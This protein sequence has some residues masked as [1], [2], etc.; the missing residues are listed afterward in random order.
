MTIAEN[1]Q[2]ITQAKEDLREAIN[3]KGGELAE[4]ARLEEFAEA[5]EYLPTVEVV[6]QAEEN[7]VNFYDYDGTVLYSYNAEEFLAM[8]E[9]PN[10][11]KQRGLVCQGWNWELSDAKEF[12]QRHG[13]LDIGATYITDDGRTRLYITVSDKT[14]KDVQIRCRTASQTEAITINWGDG[15]QEDLPNG[16]VNVFHTYGHSGDYVISFIVPSKSLLHFEGEANKFCVMGDYN[17]QSYKRIGTLKRLE[18]GDRTNIG[19]HSFDGCYNL[20]HLTLPT[21]ITSISSRAFNCCTSIQCI[22]F[23]SSVKSLNDYGTNFC[24]SLQVVSLPKSIE[25]VGA[26]QYTSSR[27]KHICLPEGLNSLGTAFFS[28]C[29]ALYRVTIPLNVTLIGTNAFNGCYNLS[30]ALIPAGVKTINGTA[31]YGCRSLAYVDLSQHTNIPTLGN[32]QVFTNVNENCK[33]VVPDAL[34]EELVS[35]T[36]WNVYAGMIVKA[37]EY[38]KP[39]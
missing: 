7:D 2:R 20:E 34:Y 38:T 25:I 5:V 9:M 11:P 39:F 13:M 10:I 16:K 32:A 14:T 31:F 15:S 29:P 28:S 24:Y 35:A 17:G 37:S 4:D 21:S 12:V 26:G 3:A 33:I 8:K 36:N 6:E 27:V 22:I 18:L 1:L 19:V 30:K 23:P